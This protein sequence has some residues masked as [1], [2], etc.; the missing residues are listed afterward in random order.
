MKTLKFTEFYNRSFEC[1]IK[2]NTRYFTEV[3]TIAV[4]ISAAYDR[5]TY[6]IHSYDNKC[7][8]DAETVLLPSPT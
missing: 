3:R 2:N 6:Y 8:F 5:Q 4:R 7:I 1:N